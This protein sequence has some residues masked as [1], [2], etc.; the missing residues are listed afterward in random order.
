[1]SG[2]PFHLYADKQTAL[3]YHCGRVKILFWRSWYVPPYRDYKFTGWAPFR[4][5]LSLTPLK[6]PVPATFR[7]IFQEALVIGWK[8]TKVYSQVK[9]TLCCESGDGPSHPGQVCP[10]DSCLLLMSSAVRT[11]TLKTSAVILLGDLDL[12]IVFM[13]NW[14]HLSIE[15]KIIIII[16]EKILCGSQS[17]GEFQLDVSWLGTSFGCNSSFL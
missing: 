8:S 14:M 1:M 2:P 9:W 10:R 13:G 4:S 12:L 17:L 5:C 15:G 3:P 6:S 11:N 16:Y 7:F